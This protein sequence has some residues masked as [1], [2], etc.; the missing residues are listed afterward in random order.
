MTQHQGRL[1]TLA[2][3]FVVARRDFMAILWSR[4]FIF[5]LLGPLFP[6]FIGAMAGSIGAHVEEAVDVPQIGLM[7]AGEDI[8]AMLTARRA[9]E[10]ALG[11]D[12]PDLVVVARLRPGE[13]GDPRKALANKRINGGNLSA[14]LSGT[15]RAPVLTGTPGR[16]AAWRGPVALI[17]ARAS[18]HGP[19]WLPDVRMA[20]TATSTAAQAHNRVLTAQGGQTLLFLLTMLLA[21]MVLSNLMEEKGNKVIEILAAAIPME[22]VFFGKLFAMLAVSFVGIG[23]WALAGAGLS[24]AGW[25]SVPEMVAPA[26][27][28][29]LFILLGVAYFAMA[30]LVLGSIFLAIGAMANSVRE[31][32]TLN[33][34]VTMAQLM[35]F[36]FASY[37]MARPGSAADMAAMILPFSSPFAMLA[38]A[39]MQESLW[40]H[41]LALGWQALWV[42]LFVRGGAALFRKRVMKSG[43]AGVARQKAGK[44]G[45][46]AA[47]WGKK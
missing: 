22:S 17:A 35:V 16:L 6:L 4:S 26:V 14:I 8:D 42:S 32:Q 27:G 29:P 45:L 1:S 11:E 12:M 10:P 38:R 24:L 46:I 34:P 15:A 36:F 5:F 18:G 43:P 37:A 30:Y 40:P 41:L 7:M 19:D 23:V 20:P 3:A 44:R 28:W 9:L 2:G 21:G 25:V 47:L 33:M 31:I 39:A 13:T